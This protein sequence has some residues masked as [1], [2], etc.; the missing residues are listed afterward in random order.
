MKP[1]RLDL[2]K[3]YIVNFD[4]LDRNINKVNKNVFKNVKIKT[5][6]HLNSSKVEFLTLGL[7]LEILT[8]QRFLIKLIKNKNFSKCNF[9]Q[10][11]INK[12][13]FLLLLDIFLISTFFDQLD[14]YNFLN[15]KLLRKLYIFIPNQVINNLNLITI[16]EGKSYLDL[17]KENNFYKFY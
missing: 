4:F 3:K 1:Y 9:F 5:E 16:C 13:K 15:V 11:H 6:K 7:I 12:N 10:T 2:Y 14:N 17:G 8:H